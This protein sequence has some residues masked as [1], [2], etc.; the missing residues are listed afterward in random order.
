MSSKVAIAWHVPVRS[1]DVHVRPTPL[2]NSSA[3][4]RKQTSHLIECVNTERFWTHVRL[5]C[6]KWTLSI[7]LRITSDGTLTSLSISRSRN[8]EPPSNLHHLHKNESRGSI[9]FPR[10]RLKGGDFANPETRKM[11]EE[12]HPQLATT[13]EIASASNRPN[14]NT[15]D[16]TVSRMTSL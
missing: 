12:R 5:S 14:R 1:S 11:I 6:F 9:V 15:Q 13:K 7:K 2:A 8:I 10:G 3:R 16:E 4:P